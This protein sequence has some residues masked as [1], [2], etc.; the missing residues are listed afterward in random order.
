MATRTGVA[1]GFI[2]GHSG[3]AT[4]STNP[5]SAAPSAPAQP[6]EHLGVS[7]PL[8]STTDV[9]RLLGV[10]PRHV[11]RLIQAGRLP[12]YNVGISDQAFWRVSPSALRLFKETRRLRV[13][14]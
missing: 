12:A 7:A 4:S 5:T 6:R 8:L 9:A 13:V 10:T 1:V 2:N 3:V 11:Q 14:K